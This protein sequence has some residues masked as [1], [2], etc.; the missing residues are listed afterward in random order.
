MRALPFFKLSPGGNPTV[1]FVARLGVEEQARVA[2][3]CLNAL[4]LDAEQAGFVYPDEA[5]LRMAGGEFCLNATRCLGLVLALEG[6]LTALPDTPAHGAAPCGLQTVRSWCGEAHTSGMPHAVTL[7]VRQDER[8]YDCSVDLPL[9][10]T[11]A[12][13]CSDVEPGVVLVRLPG[14]SHLLI[15]ASR[16][17][18][19]RHW[20]EAAATWRQ[21][22]ALDNEDAAGCIWW[23]PL[24]TPAPSAKPGHTAPPAWRCEPVVAVRHPHTVCHESACGSGSLALALA[25]ARQGLLPHGTASIV[26][27]SNMPIR[28]CLEEQ[29]GGILARVG[30]PVRLVARGEAYMAALDS[31][32]EGK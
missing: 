30:G 18:F 16:H 17:P 28:V 20:R 29:K 10:A 21:R 22:Y 19:P 3:E 1:L 27:P 9:P 2:A 26:Q 11:T 7:H 12:T 31:D 6:R 8:A 25:L 14:I 4:H 15:D 13:L 5:R 24:T 32:G 23:S